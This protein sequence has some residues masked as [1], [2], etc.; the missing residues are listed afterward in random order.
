MADLPVVECGHG[1]SHHFADDDVRVMKSGENDFVMACDCGPESLE[2]TDTRPHES[3]AHLGSLEGA[4]VSPSQWLALDDLTEGWYN[5]SPHEPIEDPR[6]PGTPAQRRTR[7][8][9]IVEEAADAKSKNRSGGADA[10]DEEARAVACPSCDANEG[11]KCQRPSGHR[12][13]KSHAARKEKAR[14][15]GVLDGE[16]AEETSQLTID[17][18][19]DLAG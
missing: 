3:E 10:V 14:D 15:E 16:D 19:E 4:C 12:V 9:E 8:R 18:L 2:E 7:K 11:R 5:E 1:T 6:W 13:R 17:D